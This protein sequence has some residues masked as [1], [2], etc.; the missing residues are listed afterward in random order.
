[1]GGAWFSI[2]VILVNGIG[3]IA[4]FPAYPLWSL[5]AISL[6]IGVISVLTVGWK[7]A[8]ADLGG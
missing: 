7:A 4:F 3:Q 5:L 2:L 1:M 6:E 8:K